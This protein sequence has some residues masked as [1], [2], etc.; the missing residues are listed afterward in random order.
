MRTQ[1]I[2]MHCVQTGAVRPKR[3]DH[4]RRVVGFCQELADRFP[5]GRLDR[6][7][8]L[9][10]AWLHDIAKDRDEERHNDPLV[11]RSMLAGYSVEADLDAVTAVIAGHDAPSGAPVRSPLESAALRLCNRMDKFNRAREKDKA[12]KKLE[13]AREKCNK[14]VRN[15]R[16]Y[17]SLDEGAYE[18]L[19]A[20]YLEKLPALEVL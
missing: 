5:E 10:A 16:R 19:R 2:L 17:G 7:L 4:T 13:K 8:L 12:E 15:L 14:T 20:F 18:T 11:V 3:A 6:Q 1:E 9:D